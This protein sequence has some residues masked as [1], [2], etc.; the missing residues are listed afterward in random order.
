MRWNERRLLAT[1]WKHDEEGLERR[2]QQQLRRPDNYMCGS[3]SRNTPP[4]ERI[5]SKPHE[6][7]LPATSLHLPS[8]GAPKFKSR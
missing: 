2:T 4:L 7:Q 3:L 5:L 8:A 6:R 1:A